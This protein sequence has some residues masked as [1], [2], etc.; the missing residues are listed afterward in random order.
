MESYPIDVKVAYN[1]N[2]EYRICM[3]NLFQMNQS[4]HLPTI[5]PMD[6]LD[7][8]TRDELTYDEEAATKVMDFVFLNTETNVLFQYLYDHAAGLMLSTDRSIGLTILY[9]YDYFADF[10]QCLVAFFQ[11]PTKLTNVLPCYVRLVDKIH[12]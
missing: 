7:E 11:T 2:A 4:S 3:R 5:T 12:R 10:H 1:N 9:S 6:E 8:E